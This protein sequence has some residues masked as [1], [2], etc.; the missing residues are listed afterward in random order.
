MLWWVKLYFAAYLLI[1]LVGFAVEI[2]QGTTLPRWLL[3]LASVCCPLLP[4]LVYWGVGADWVRGMDLRWWYWA[5][6]IALLVSVTLELRDE[7]P[8][9]ELTALE[10]L[11][12][13]AAA[14][15][16]IALLLAPTLW[17][18]YLLVFEGRF[19]EG[20]GFYPF[21]PG[22]MKPLRILPV[23]TM[24]FAITPAEWAR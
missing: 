23:E 1:A 20:V 7:F 22:D 12:T 19:A 11:V 5:G 15:V 21:V 2:R 13:L 16:L 17:W 10:N 18:G 24:P 6:V 3:S 14:L 4:A 8:D 9:P